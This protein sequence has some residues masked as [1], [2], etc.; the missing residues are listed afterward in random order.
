M[1]TFWSILTFVLLGTAGGFLLTRRYRSASLLACIIA[2]IL[3]SLSLSWLASLA[4][5]GKGYAA[6]SP[7]GVLFGVAGAFLFPLA[8]CIIQKKAAQVQSS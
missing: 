6:F 1:I 5:L 4:G 3:G 7:W 8:V 2:G